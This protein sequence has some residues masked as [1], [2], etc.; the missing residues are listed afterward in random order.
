[1]QLSAYNFP[2]LCRILKVVYEVID[3]MIK[4]S[5]VCVKIA[6]T[7]FYKYKYRN[8]ELL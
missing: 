5:D 1:V 4:N 8:Y 3:V 2:R 7:Y 6:F